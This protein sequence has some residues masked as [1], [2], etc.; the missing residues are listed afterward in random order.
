MSK[1]VIHI[2][3]A[4]LAGLAAAVRLK[5][6][7]A[8]I[9]LHE[10]TSQAGG[11]CRSYHDAT[12][13]ITIDNGNHVILSGNHTALAY[14]DLIGGRDRLTT[15]EGAIFPFVDLATGE[16]WTLRPNDGRLPWW[17][18]D[19]GRRVP[20]TRARDYFGAAPLMWAG[21]DKTIADV[22]RCSG[23]LYDR[24]WHPLLLAALNTDPA[25]SSASLAAATMR[26]TLAK[27]GRAC[28]PLIASDGLSSA[29]VEPALRYLEA[30]GVRVQYGHRL[31]AL[32]LDER[33][34][35]KLDFGED[36]VP[37]A[38]GDGVVLAV[39]ALV[40]L[41]LVPGLQA[42]SQFRSIVNG[43]FRIAPPPGL[44]PM[45]GIVN[46]TVEWI[47]AFR[48]RLS[49]TI[50]GADRLLDTPRETLARNLWKEV[51]VITGLAEDLPPWQIIRE[52]RATF[53]A[54]PGEDAKRPATD[55]AW[56]NLVLAGDWTATGLPATIEG[57]I[58]SG[59]KAADSVRK[60]QY[61][62][63]RDYDRTTEH[64]PVI[65]TAA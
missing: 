44:A 14:L 41:T 10:A 25:E 6:A 3:G 2:I 21:R 12:L 30:Q 11:R 62:L 8:D 42:P 40:A 7:G 38:P 63:S 58:R 33:R 35:A 56:D 55:T 64:R 43:H 53:A 52:R 39:P 9:A 18:F 24:L 26:E 59:N 27:G 22:M 37:L 4:G 19:T 34:V 13:G 29:F 51:S 28:R 32:G 31:R 50:S 15:P 49:I 46:G 20:G 48:D 65:G 36:S 61:G 57:A 5:D 54:L 23:R 17:V 1:P 47:F 45:T 16:R 60:K